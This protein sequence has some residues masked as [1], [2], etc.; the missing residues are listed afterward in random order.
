MNG[1][2]FYCENRVVRLLAVLALTLAAARGASAADGAVKIHLGTLV[3]KGSSYFKHLQT[4]GEAWRTS[5]IALTIYP[6][7]R[8]GSESDMVRRMRLGQLQAGM[9]TAVGLQDIEPAVSGLQDMPMMFRSLDEVDHVGKS[10]HPM[11]EKRLAD[12]GF[13]VLAWCDTGW[14]R[15]F[16]RQPVVKPDD[17]RRAKLFVWSGSTAEVDI[18]RSVGCSPV[19]L[20]TADIPQ[21]L[22]T[23]LIDAVPLP[24]TIALAGQVD[25]VARHMI[26]L[27]WAPL[28]GA[29]VITRKAWDNI[30]EASRD[31]V[32][33][34]AADAGRQI[35][36]DGR[37]ESAESVDAMQKRG[38]QVHPVTAD[39][40]A[41][42]RRE[43]EPTYAKIRGP[44]VPAEIFDEVV[45]Q[46]KT[47]REAHE[48]E[49][50]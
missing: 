17:L 46:L 44:V 28:V 49:K 18:Y 25:G 24:P 43:V 2:I 34:A 33:K 29:V 11:L 32:R 13:V 27:N 1:R 35:T 38:L 20:E 40:L 45:R 47:Y 31:A 39:G 37:R 15:I 12:K 3:P 30:P 5:G 41:E 22:R 9:L 10:L 50:K 26:D 16:S 19:P 42:W 21:G 6:D 36:E 48:S 4:M 23:G 14:V 8:M 7:G